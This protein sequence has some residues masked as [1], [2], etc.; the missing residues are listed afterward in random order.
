MKVFFSLLMFISDSSFSPSDKVSTFSL[1]VHSQKYQPKPPLR[2]VQGPGLAYVLYGFGDASGA[3]FGSSWESS[4][5]THYRFGVWGKDV[6]GKSS[7]YRELR[8]LVDSLEEM[9]KEQKL[10]GTEVYFFTDNSTAENAFFKGSSTSR[11]LHDL[12]TRLR[13]FE[14]DEGCKIILVHVSGER[15]KLQGSDGLSRGNLLEGVMTG[16]D[17]LSYIPLAQTA[18]DRSPNLERWIR[19]WSEEEKGSRGFGLEVLD[20]NDWF[21]KGHDIDGG[22]MVGDFYYPQYRNGVYLWNPPPAAAEI[23]CEEIRKAR[24]KRDKSSHIFI[25]PRLLTPY[26]RSHLHRAA[27]LI[28]EIPAGGEYWPIEM[29][30][31]LILAIFS[32][33]LSHRPWQFRQSPSIVELGDRL[34]RMWRLGDYSQ[35]PILRKLWEQTRTLEYM[36]PRV[37]FRMLH[38]FGEFGVPCK[39]GQKR[40]RSSLETKEGCGK[41]Y[42]SKKR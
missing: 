26:W 38:C 13:K 21:V 3:G 16:K 7:N 36:P 42:D 33:R 28:L 14:M 24:T 25:C 19:S 4:E 17:I 29:H 39:G 32:P 11:L 9:S 8:N 6:S 5:G 20:E 30:E 18:L 34:Q 31:P 27:D 35:G 37:V 41:I 22:Y 12:V 40:S 23:A 10:R 15:M 1:R 2:L